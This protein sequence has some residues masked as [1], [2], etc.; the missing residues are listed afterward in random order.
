MKPENQDEAAR[1][2]ETGA[3][4]LR[5]TTGAWTGQGFRTF[6]IKPADALVICKDFAGLTAE[7]VE[8]ARQTLKG[9]VEGAFGDIKFLV[10]DLAMRPGA[11]AP[12]SEDARRLLG[13]IANLILAAPIVTIAHARGVIGGA[14]LELALACNMLICD[15]NARFSFAA[16]PV[17]AVATYVLLAQKIGFV[18]AERLMEHEDV[19][20]PGQ[21]RELL[22]LKDTTVS[23]PEGLEAF[24]ARAHRRHNSA[25]AMYRA[26]RIATPLISELFGDQTRN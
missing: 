24:L 25:A 23:S 14:D 15:E 18:R 6:E 13:E 16:D 11:E 1:L 3:P 20:T 5:G 9:A 7:W 10:F 22:L 12:R 26:Q 4:R 8:E 17:E 21:M 19:L 2:L